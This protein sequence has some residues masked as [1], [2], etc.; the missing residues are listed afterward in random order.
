MFKIEPVDQIW[1][2]SSPLPIPINLIA[3]HC[4]LV[5]NDKNGNFERWEV[6]Q[7]PNCCRTS[8]GYVHLNLFPPE[9]GI[10]SN[11]FYSKNYKFGP[12]KI[13]GYL[14]GEMAFLMSEFLK[15]EAKNYPYKDDYKY[16]GPN[17]NSFIKWVILNFRGC[18]LK[19][20]KKAIGGHFIK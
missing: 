15:K 8:W 3:V 6:W 4:W 9:K 11:L 12:T 10:I 5:S 17:S 14:K 20:P 16:L 2:L 13:E 7:D 1:L 18:G 19:M